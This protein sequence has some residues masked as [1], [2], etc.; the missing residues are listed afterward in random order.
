MAKTRAK[1]E[2]DNEKCTVTVKLASDLLN[3][4]GDPI[5]ILL[6]MGAF[7]SFVK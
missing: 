5:I 3:L 6:L 1:T 7:T 2:C 4:A